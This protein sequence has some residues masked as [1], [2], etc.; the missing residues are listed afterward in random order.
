MTRK[1]TF[2]KLY[3]SLM[4]KRSSLLRKINEDLSL[5]HSLDEGAGDE[6]D[7]AMDTEQHEIHS[8]LAAFESR[9]LHQIEEAILQIRR[10]TYGTCEACHDPIP[11]T[12]LNALPF[13]TLCIQ[14]QREEEL[15]GGCRSSWGNDLGGESKAV[16]RSSRSAG[17]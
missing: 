8:Q 7:L 4:D 2:V 16:S 1:E 15:S 13:T 5:T 17:R 14:C 3:R 12:R 9:E 11:I 6:A 10:G